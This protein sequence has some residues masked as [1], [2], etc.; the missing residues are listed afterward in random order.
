MVHLWGVRTLARHG[1]VSLVI[2]SMALLC[3][4]WGSMRRP[5]AQNQSVRPPNAVQRLDPKAPGRRSNPADRGATYQW[6]DERAVRVTTTFPDAVAVTE[7]VAG[8]D[9]RTRLSAAGHDLGEFAVDRVAAGNDVLTFKRGDEQFVRAAGRPGAQLTLDWSNRQAYA[10]WKD[11]ATDPAV[12]L[13]WQGDL[14][15]ARGAAVVDFHHETLD[16]RTEW[17]DGFA[18]RATRSE[19]QRPDPRT[20]APSRGASLES[21]LTRD[22]LEVGRS[23]WYPEEQVYLWSVPGLTSG[24][25]DAER[26]KDIGGWTFAP[27][28]AWAN[29]QTYAFHYFHTLMNTQGFVAATAAAPPLLR[30]L[31]DA[32]APTLHA[33]EPGCD[34][35]HWLDGSIFRPCCDIHDRCYE[36]YGCTWKSWWEWWS[37][38]K[39]VGCNFGL[40]LCIATR[41]PPLSPSYP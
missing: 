13:E 7:R 30:R 32:V 35:L 38:W 26:M 34:G 1:R 2:F 12:A 28:L 37:G 24:Y 31:V 23:R 10:M 11:L 40:T 15:R 19:G 6:L 3:A 9:L 41:Y 36:K 4:A 39:C 20:G 5:A 21:R 29:L 16:V 17:F 27:D 33:N 22:N 25:M 18:A 8:G 14:I